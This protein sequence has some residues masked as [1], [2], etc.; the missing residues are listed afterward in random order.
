MSFLTDKFF[1]RFIAK[2]LFTFGLLYLG[3]LAV[4]GLASP[5]GYYSPFVDKYLDYISGIKNLLLY[6][7]KAILSIFGIATNMEPD[8]A[9]RIV[10]GRGVW[11]AMDCVG[12]GVYSFWIAYIVAGTITIKKKMGWILGGLLLLFII[13]DIRITLF[14]VAINKGWPMPLGIN[15]HTWF[16]IFAYGAIFTMM[17]FFEKN[18]R[19]SSSQ[20][21]V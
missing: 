3:T 17:Y 8:Y 2:F 16:T 13:N 6:S 12:Y 18:V 14:L 4:I 20:K 10:N 1:L 5:D 7:T 9:I 11:I 19:K 15:H 21:K